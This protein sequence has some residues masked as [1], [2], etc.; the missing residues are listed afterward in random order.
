[1]AARFAGYAKVRGDLPTDT[2]LFGARAQ[3]WQQE[4]EA[5]TRQVQDGVVSDDDLAKLGIPLPQDNRPVLF[6]VCGTGVPWWVGPDADTARAVE[7]RYKWQPIGYPAAPFPMSTSYEA[8]RSELRRQFTLWRAQVERCGAALGGYSQGAIVTSLFW[9]QDVKPETG[10]CHWAKDHITKA[11]AWGNPMR[12]QG[13]AYPDAGA[14]IAPADS[15]GVTG[16]LMV[17]TPD[18][19]RNYAHKGDLYTDCSG[20]SGE[21]KTAI[22]QIV[23]GTNVFRGPDSIIAQVIETIQ[24]PLPGA[25]AMLKAMLDAGI[26]FAAGTGP[27][28]NYDIRPAIEFLREA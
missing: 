24:Q 23:R 12:E 28:V 18:W 13:K 21:M 22:W 5:R 16:N 8:G 19:W 3:A 27:H 1:M 4:Y 26:F 11:V 20:E 17:D 10:S 9:E 14:P 7:D 15:H 2:D 25:I 6:T